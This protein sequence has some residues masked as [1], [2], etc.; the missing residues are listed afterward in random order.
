MSFFWTERVYIFKS[1][2]GGGWLSPTAK[3]FKLPEKRKIEMTRET[4]DL[5]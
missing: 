4:A 5:A 1:V 3:N 2:R